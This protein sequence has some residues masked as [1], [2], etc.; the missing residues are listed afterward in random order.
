MN[1]VFYDFETSG[2]DANFDQPIQLAAILTNENFE[3]LDEPINEICKLKEGVIANPRALLVNKVDIE[4]LKSA[5]CFYDF[6]DNI[7]EKLTSWSPATF[8]GYNSIFFDEEFLRN[9][10]YQLSL[11]F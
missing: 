5:Q 10:L 2:T 3:I 1:Y 7:H 9:S 11:R 6:M 8:I 4:L